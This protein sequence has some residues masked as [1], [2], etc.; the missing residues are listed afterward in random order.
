MVLIV[1]FGLG[2]QWWSRKGRSKDLDRLNMQM[3]A[4]EFANAFGEPSQPYSTRRG[5]G[6]DPNMPDDFPLHEMLNDFK[7]RNSAL[8]KKLMDLKNQ[9]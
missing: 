9:N 2:Y 7:G 8:E 3:K 4:R 6:A 1:G 5:K